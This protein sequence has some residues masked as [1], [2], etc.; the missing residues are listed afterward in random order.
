[1]SE[2]AL[3]SRSEFVSWR[4]QQ[5]SELIQTLPLANVLKLRLDRRFQGRIDP[6]DVLQEAFLDLAEEWPSHSRKQSFPLFL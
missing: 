5:T 3:G 1:M 4:D 6:S 2:P